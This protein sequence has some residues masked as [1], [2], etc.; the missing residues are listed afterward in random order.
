MARLIDTSVLIAAERQGRSLANLKAELLEDEFVIA[1]ITA[2][3]LMVGIHYADSP[4]RR[5][6]RESYL[7]DILQSVAVIDFDL[8]V[9]RLHARLTYEMRRA[10]TLIGAHDMQI[11]A[12][13]I[14]GGYRLLTANARKYSRVPGLSIDPYP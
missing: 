4:D 8:T 5:R 1:A 6:D 14:A 7:E 13:A 9:A 11:A 2:S 3:E 10:G 12:T